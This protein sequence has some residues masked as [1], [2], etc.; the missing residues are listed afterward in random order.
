MPT[1]SNATPPCGY[2]WGRLTFSYSANGTVTLR[3]QDQGPSTTCTYAGS[4]RQVPCAGLEPEGLL[5][6]PMQVSL[7]KPGIIRM[8]YSRADS[9]WRPVRFGLSGASSRGSLAPEVSQA[10]AQ[11]YCPNA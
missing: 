5:P 7:V 10:D 11:R 6:S 2:A 1:V 4:T 3:Y 9:F 8:V